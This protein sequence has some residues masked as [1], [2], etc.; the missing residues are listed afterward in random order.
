LSALHLTLAWRPFLDPLNLHEWWYALL[1]PL[2]LGISVAYKAVRANSLKHYWKHVF[3]MTAQIVIA[4]VGLGAASYVLLILI[5]PRLVPM[6][7]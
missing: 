6:G 1:V 3:I 7:E 2:A 5:V 4:M